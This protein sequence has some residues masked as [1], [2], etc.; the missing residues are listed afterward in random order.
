MYL[1]GQMY[2]TTVFDFFSWLLVVVLGLEDRKQKCTFIVVV[3]HFK[4]LQGDG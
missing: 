3:A 4:G 2:Y 1:W